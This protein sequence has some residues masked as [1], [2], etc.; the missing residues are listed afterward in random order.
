MPPQAGQVRC[1]PAWEI[2]LSVP[3]RAQNRWVACQ[4]L[5]AV[6][7]A[8]TLLHAACQLHASP[9]DSRVLSLLKYTL[10]SAYALRTPKS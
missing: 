10:S 9:P 8:F 3:Q 6:R 5:A 2:V 4:P 1:Q 7:T